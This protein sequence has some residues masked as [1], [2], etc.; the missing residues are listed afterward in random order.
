MSIVDDPIEMDDDAV[1][2]SSSSTSASDHIDGDGLQ[3]PLRQAAAAR[4]R[5]KRKRGV[6][7]VSIRSSV[8]EYAKPRK[9][10]AKQLSSEGK[11]AASAVGAKASTVGQLNPTM[12]EEAIEQTLSAAN[13]AVKAEYA[14]LPGTL[15]RTESGGS[16]LRV[17][18]M[19]ANRVIHRTMQRY[20]R[21]EMGK[22]IQLQSGT[23]A[24]FALVF[25]ANSSGFS[26]SSRADKTGDLAGIDG[27]YNTV[28]A[29]LAG[30]N[31][32]M[33]KDA[34]LA[35]M[36]RVR[37]TSLDYAAPSASAERMPGQSHSMSR[38]A[39]V[40]AGG[41]PNVHRGTQHAANKRS[42]EWLHMVARSDGNG[43]NLQHT[44]AD[45]TSDLH[46]TAETPLNAVDTSADPNAVQSPRNLVAGSYAANTLMMAL[47]GAK[48][49]NGN[50]SG[51]TKDVQAFT[52]GA[53]PHAADVI[54]YQL[55]RKAA[56]GVEPASR[57]YY[58]D[59]SVNS[60][61]PL[62]EYYNMKLDANEFMNSTDNTGHDDYKPLPPA[63][64]QALTNNNTNEVEGLT[65]RY[66]QWLKAGGDQN[67]LPPADFQP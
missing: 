55:N 42:T 21:G 22:L 57:A 60:T 63:I 28:P 4:R 48:P 24:R 38:A 56:D 39:G 8:N 11:Q 54:R 26:G 19:E 51:F 2:A 36:K 53:D 43:V 5:P 15:A 33:E 41:S 3:D 35:K 49:E 66:R 65:K 46:A 1:A 25:T 18:L 20:I 40:A 10:Y 27:A 17:A 45:G 14:N 16:R 58:M 31:N 9:S 62:A 30:K 44:N 52:N 7:R 67:I 61:A 13:E 64:S 34:E 6:E 59:S 12:P 23:P 47:E 29:A 37:H 50:R 32:R